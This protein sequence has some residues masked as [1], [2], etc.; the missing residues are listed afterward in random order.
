MNRQPRPSGSRAQVGPGCGLWHQPLSWETEPNSSPGCTEW[1]GDGRGVGARA[2]SLPTGKGD[3]PSAQ[4]LRNPSA[5]PAPRREAHRARICYGQGL[6][7]LH[8][9]ATGFLHRRQQLLVQLLIGLVGRNVDPVKAGVGERMGSQASLL[10]SKAGL[11]QC[12]RA[13]AGIPARSSLE[14]S[15]LFLKM[16]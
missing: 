14:N 6:F 10:L 5:Q 11:Y 1:M 4:G 7:S 15:Q 9:K 16:N 3:N 8:G 13:L 12:T 2:P